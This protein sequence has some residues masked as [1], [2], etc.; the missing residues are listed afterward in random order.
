MNAE[1]IPGEQRYQERKARIERAIRLQPVDRIP[2]IFMGTAFAPRYMGMSMAQFCANPADRVDVTLAAMDRLGAS[3]FDGINALPAGRITVAL[4]ELWLSRVAVPGRDLPEESLWQVAEVE[5]MGEEEYDAILEEGWTSFLSHYMH[6]VISAA[7]L[8]EDRRWSRAHLAA[9]IAQFRD[10]GYVPI[11]YG[12]FSIPFEY[13]CGGRSMAQFYQDLYRIPDK[14]E[15]VMEVMLPELIGAAVRTAGRSGIRCVWLGGWRSASSM[16]SPRLWNRFVF[17]YFQRMV[18]ALA[19]QDILSVL[20]LDQDWTRDLARLLE[21][22]AGSCLLNL[23]G[24]TDIRRAREILGDH[25]ALMGDVPA[26]LFSIGAPEE[27]YDHVHQLVNDIGPAGLLLCPGCDAPIDA[28]PEN[29][30]AFVAAC[31]EFGAVTETSGRN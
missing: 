22:P 14:V 31:Q 20:H 5:M 3:V 29:M 19:E 15:R 4:T 8:E 11:S 2:A 13:L 27:I 6:R 25:M 17:P 26:T 18:A 21:L 12:A 7:E 9:V 16:I 23:D 30:E 24:S 10:R 28:K 1:S